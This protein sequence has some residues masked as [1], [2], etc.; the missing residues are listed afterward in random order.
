VDPSNGGKNT[1]DRYERFLDAYGT[2]AGNNSLSQKLNIDYTSQDNNQTM[3]DIKEVNAK[4]K[5]EFTFF[6]MLT[7]IVMTMRFR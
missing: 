3:L 2:A 4:N 7:V 6:G 1:S 5:C